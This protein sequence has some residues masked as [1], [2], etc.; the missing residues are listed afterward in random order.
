MIR[1]VDEGLPAC[2][3][4]IVSIL[5]TCVDHSIPFLAVCKLRKSDELEVEVGIENKEEMIMAKFRS[6]F[7]SIKLIA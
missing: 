7:T 1:R 2:V 6:F 4:K 3:K 5:E